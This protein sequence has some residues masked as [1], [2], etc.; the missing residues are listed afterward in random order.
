MQL[1]IRV[2]EVV[3]GKCPF[4]YKVGDEW[5]Y[6]ERSLALCH[7]ANHVILPFATALRFGGEIPWGEK[8]KVRVCCPDS[9]NILVFEIERLNSKDSLKSS[10]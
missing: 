8:G 3:R 1:R 2:V 7:W 6:G 10:S 4:G 9:K 5:I